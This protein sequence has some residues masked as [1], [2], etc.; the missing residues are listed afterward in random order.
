[1]N[2]LKASGLS[3]FVLVL[4]LA[5][6]KPAVIEYVKYT[7]DLAV[8]RI[9]AEE[10][11]KEYDAGNVVFVDSRGQAAFDVEHLP[12]AIVVPYQP[13]VEQSYDNLP[14]GKKIIVYC[15]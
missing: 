7:N 3:L 4:F 15:S 6:Q 9:S 11:K 12:G 8:P 5:C 13:G 10:A 1:M 2:K 14:K